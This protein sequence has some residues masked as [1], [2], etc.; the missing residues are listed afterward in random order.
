MA[1]DYTID[2]TCVPKETFGTQGVL[3]RL[4]GRARAESIIRLF[5]ENGDDRSPDQM[6]FEFVRSSPAGEEETQVI[7]VQDLLDQAAELDA[8]APL[9]IGCR[10]NRRAQP[11]GC[12]DAIQYPL[13]SSAERWLLDRL[14]GIDQ[15][16]LW[17]LLR[18]GVQEL[19]YD[20]KTVEP[21]RASGVYF[22]SPTLFMR[23][24]QDF[25]MTSDQVFEMIFL[26]GD[27]Q[28]SHAGMLLQF[29]DAVPRV[30]EAGQIVELMNNAHSPD[31][32]ASRYPFKLAA[33]ASDDRTI[34][35]LKRFLASL[36]RAWAL[37]V[38]LKLDV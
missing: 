18:Q 35:E 38:P 17:L 4:K 29:T 25:I 37:N 10:A 26:L 32:K 2:L 28:P 24:L 7:V 13:T 1:I 16:L 23:D 11:F 19:G 30:T 34:A 33:E 14:P 20:G 9:C 12:M 21:L 27:I 5:R 36:H 6:G 31:E 15:P 3:E 22:E 8:Y